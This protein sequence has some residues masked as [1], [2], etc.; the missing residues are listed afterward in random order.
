MGYNDENRKEGAGSN[1]FYRWI[2]RLV[3]VA[4]I[5]G[6]TSFLTPGFRIHGLWSYIIAAVIIS[7]LDYLVEYFMGVDASPFGKGI[8]GFIISAI[9]IYAAQFFVPSMSVSI[10]GALL[11]SVV[12]GLLDMVFPVRVL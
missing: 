5:L 4:I 7:A 2:G 9:I 12:I 10:I 11:A 3:M 6:V 1:S 8:K